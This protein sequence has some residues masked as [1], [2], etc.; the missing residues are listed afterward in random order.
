MQ[1]YHVLVF[2]DLTAPIETPADGN[3]LVEA[4]DSTLAAAQALAALGGG[5]ADG[6]TVVLAQMPVERGDM[7]FDC[8]LIDGVF[9]CA[10]SVVRCAVPA[11]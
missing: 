9:T 11:L 4:L 3:F 6:I 10:A 5:M 7:F 1:Q 8:L 2:R